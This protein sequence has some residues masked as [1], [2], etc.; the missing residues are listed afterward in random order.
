[1]EEYRSINSIKGLEGLY[2]VSN[3]G[4]VKRV[5]YCCLSSHTTYREKHFEF[6][7]NRTRYNNLTIDGKTYPVSKLVAMVFPEICGE[8]FEGCEVDHINT[9]SKDNRAENLKVV[10]SHSEN[11]SN[12]LTRKH[13]SE[14]RK[15]YMQDNCKY[16]TLDKEYQRERRRKYLQKYREEHREH[17][18]AQRMD[19]YWKNK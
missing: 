1:M 11:M 18:N 14:A 12:P 10:G 19:Y 16:L 15:K 5:A 4:N 7:E 13:I 2:W 6:L 9:N 3:L 17:I 8:W